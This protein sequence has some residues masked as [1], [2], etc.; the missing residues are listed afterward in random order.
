MTPKN[1]ES[2]I[3]AESHNINVHVALSVCSTD[4]LESSPDEDLMHG[5]TESVSP[6]IL[7]LQ[8]SLISALHG[9]DMVTCPR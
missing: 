7:T 4:S 5:I 1:K 3:I 9:T 2:V 6:V 8:L